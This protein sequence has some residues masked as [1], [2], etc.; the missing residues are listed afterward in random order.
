MIPKKP[1]VIIKQVAE[2]LN[3]SESLVDDLISFYYKEVRKNL[4]S[5][6]HPKV[7]LVGLGDFII[8]KRSVDRLTTKF[9]NLSKEYNTDTFKNYHNLKVAESKLERLA[10]ATKNIEEFAELKKKFRDG[11]KTGKH[12]EE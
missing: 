11:R 3:L 1:Q 4:S 10:H 6:E 9:I 2:D 5:L 8:L 12:L 7:N